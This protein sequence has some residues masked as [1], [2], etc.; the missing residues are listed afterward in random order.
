MNQDIVNQKR[1]AIF[2]K[3]ATLDEK[4]ETLYGTK[5]YRMLSNFK[6]TYYAVSKNYRELSIAIAKYEGNSTFWSTLTHKDRI[7]FFRELS[8]LLHNYL[9]STFTL[10]QHNMELRNKCDRISVEYKSKID[11]LQSNDCY[12]FIRGLRNI[13]QHIELPSLLGHFS[14]EKINHPTIQSI[15]LGKQSLLL[16]EKDICSRSERE[17]FGRYIRA[18]KEIDLKIALNQYQCLLKDFYNWFYHRF[19]QL[20]SKELK[21][22]DA[23]D[24]EIQQLQL[25]LRNI[26]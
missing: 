12:N 2:E 11:A 13:T 19:D 9:S 7:L 23:V 10:I 17:G 8:R 20:Y 1:I 16:R 14:R 18:E 25:E 24:N 21:E 3:W 4:L 26:K 5:I 22:Y 6:G 15:I